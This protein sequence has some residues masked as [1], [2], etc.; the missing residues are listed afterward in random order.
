MVIV[1]VGVIMETAVAKG[2]NLKPA[3]AGEPGMALVRSHCLNGLRAFRD[4]SAGAAH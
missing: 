2:R 1:M 3:G 4:L